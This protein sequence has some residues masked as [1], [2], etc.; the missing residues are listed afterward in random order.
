M[1]LT[2]L[3]CAIV[4]AEPL[5][6]SQHASLMEVY[7]GLGTTSVSRRMKFLATPVLDDNFLQ[8]ARRRFVL[9]STQVRTAPLRALDLV[10]NLALS[11][12]CE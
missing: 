7:D 12:D 5:I 1:I 10:A 9:V 3:L 6:D 8:G 2:V 4:A 11:F